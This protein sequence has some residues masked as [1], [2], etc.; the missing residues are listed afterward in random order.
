MKKI[1][2][3]YYKSFL[4]I[5]D[6][7][8]H[9]CCI[10]WEIDIDEDSLAY[11]KSLD[12]K[13]GEKLAKNIE[14]DGDTACFRLVGTE[15]RCPF[16]KENG[17]CEMILTL[18]E[19]S[20]CNICTEHPRFY[21]LLS[22]REE[23]GLGL[24]CEEAARLILSQKEK[25]TLEIL[26][27]DGINDELSSW[28]EALLFMREKLFAILQNE[29][30]TI[31]ERALEMLTESQANIP[32]KPISEWQNILLSLEQLD[33]LWGKT[34]SSLTDAHDEPLSEFEKPFEKLL[35]YFIYRHTSEAADSEDFS[36]RVAF[37]YFGYYI[38]RL[39]C[40]VKKTKDGVCTLSDL[41]E[42]ARQ[43]SSEIEYSVEN[44]EALLDILCE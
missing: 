37:A 42:L 17:L 18:G 33:P 1:A 32:N 19:D 8:H 31:E 22:D 2:P 7:C 41:A 13:F 34:L 29:G 12:G 30:K 27:D 11:Y 40:S 36:A 6:K 25:T 26:E 16:L 35:L 43:Y 10:G 4:C 44:T 23:V 14:T 3:N 9:S 28:E 24:C 20:L 15:E 5:A 38:I 39:L 21:H